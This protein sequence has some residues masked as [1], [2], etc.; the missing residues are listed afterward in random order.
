[1]V[2]DAC[3][4]NTKNPGF[5]AVSVVMLRLALGRTRR[6]PPLHSI[7]LVFRIFKRHLA[8]HYGDAEDK[9]R[10]P[11]LTGVSSDGPDASGMDR[12][13]SR[14]AMRV[15]LSGFPSDNFGGLTRSTFTVY[16]PGGTSS[17]R[18]VPSGS[19]IA[20]YSRWSRC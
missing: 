7:S 2:H 10:M 5:T 18:N 12:S 8:G 11:R 20:R 4:S 15:N 3:R 6:L 16:S 17:M 14:A 9:W 1:M 19:N 13:V